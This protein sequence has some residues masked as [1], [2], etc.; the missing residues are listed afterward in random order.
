YV[1]KWLPIV[2]ASQSVKS[3]PQEAELLR[4]WVNVVDYE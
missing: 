2:A 3:K 1:Q 4:K